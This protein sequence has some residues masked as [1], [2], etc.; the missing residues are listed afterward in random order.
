MKLYRGYSCATRFRQP[1]MVGRVRPRRAAQN[2]QPTTACRD[3]RA[4]PFAAGD[5]ITLEFMGNFHPLSREHCDHEP[6]LFERAD[7][8]KSKRFELIHDGLR[9]PLS[10][11]TGEGRGEGPF[12]GSWEVPCFFSTCSRLMNQKEPG[13]ARQRLGLRWLHRF[14]NLAANQ[15]FFVKP[16]LVIGAA[17]L[18][19]VVGVFLNLCVL[20]V[21]VFKL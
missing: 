6:E 7:V 2:C 13:S 17:I 3:G 1:A 21:S 14:Q 19:P 18:Q 8:S 9:F 5:C 12:T 10:R 11:R 4:L 15:T 20:R 16:H